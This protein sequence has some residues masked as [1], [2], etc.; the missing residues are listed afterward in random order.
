[1]PASK[2]KKPIDPNFPN[3]VYAANPLVRVYSNRKGG[4][5]LA[6]LFIGEWMKILDDEIPDKGR[7]HV[8]YRGGKGYINQNDYTYSRFLEIF[9]IDVNQGDSILIQTPDDRRILID[10]GKGNEAYSFIRDKYNLHAKDHYIDFEA[11]VATHCDDDHT[12]GL[13]N[14]LKDPRIAVKRFYH[15][16]LFRR[17]VKGK[18]PGAMV[19]GRIFGL[20]ER[21]RLSDSPELTA[22]MKKIVEAANTAKSNLPVVIKKMKKI[23]R[24]KN[25]IDLPKGGFVFERL[26]ASDTY[27]PPY[28]EKNKYLTIEVLWPHTRKV[29]GKLSYTA[30]GDAGKTVNGNSIVLHLKHGRQ[31]ILLAGDLN[32]KSMDDMLKHFSRSGRSLSGRLRSHVYKAAHH[33][34]QDFS[35]PFLKAVKPDAAVISSGDDRQDAHGHPR[36]VLMGTITKYSRT[37]KPAVFSTELA[38]IYKPLSTKQRKKLVEGKIQVYEKSNEGIVHLRSD[39]KRLYLGTVFGRKPPERRFKNI[40]WKWDIWPE[41]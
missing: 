6:N 19:G 9:F 29:D 12:K 24:W 11:I 10:G 27:M 41:V 17:K 30:Y 22:L 18:D 23:D 1:M 38:A 20:V 35:L 31:R 39:G 3:Y 26:D 25:R 36:A 15:N 8:R 34:S 32:C 28:D 37:A 2:R 5:G 7:I 13:I 14:I 21:P 4:S 40:L 33:G 16:G